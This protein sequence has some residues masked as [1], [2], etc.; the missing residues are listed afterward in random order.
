MQSAQA[1]SWDWLDTAYFTILYS[2]GDAE[3]CQSIA[4]FIDPLYSTLAETTGHHP[5]TPILIRLYL[6]AEAYL[7]TNLIAKDNGLAL[8]N[9]DSHE[10][11]L[12]VS[13]IP[14]RNPETLAAIMRA[15]IA[16]YFVADLTGDQLPWPLAVGF[17]EYYAGMKAADIEG[18]L[19]ALRNAHQKKLQFS[20]AELFQP[21]IVLEDP[22]LTYAESYALA[23]Y[24]I[25][26]Y[27]LSNFMRLLSAFEI[28]PGYRSAIESTYGVSARELETLWEDSLDTFVAGHWQRNIFVD[29]DLT[30]A[31]E[32]LNMGAYTAAVT[33]L[34]QAIHIMQASGQD[35]SQ[36]S[37][38]VN[39]AEQG[40]DAG[41]FVA[42]ARQA[43]EDH[44]YDDVLVLVAEAR[45][46][47]AALDDSS[48][49]EELS[50]YQARAQEVLSVREELNRVTGLLATGQIE[51]ARIALDETTTR[52]I[53]LGDSQGV[54]LARQ[55]RH[56]INSLNRKITAG[57]LILG[58]LILVW[59][60]YLRW[61]NFKY[62]SDKTESGLV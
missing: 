13:R 7:T 58:G 31:Q 6:D 59:N 38:L 45:Q 42:E 22:Q 30:Y 24:L 60:L 5:E 34:N 28:E 56:R 40:R 46:A 20:W 27:G 57:L 23:S 2:E 55:M 11:S 8:Q 48:R 61:R 41:E 3:L 49:D 17:G 54:E 35:A 44:L 12:I 33:E 53:A 32:L 1:L 4:G 21:D 9:P 14:N 62:S 16:R 51:A 29:Y 19:S 39:V 43:L 37:S 10:I 26:R 36:A 47:Y 15:G 50:A 18:K 25:E 52:L